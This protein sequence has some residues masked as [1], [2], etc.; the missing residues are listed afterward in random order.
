MLE[1]RPKLEGGSARPDTDPAR[2]QRRRMAIAVV[3]LL[4]ALAVVALKDHDAWFG[5]GDGQLIADGDEPDANAPAPTAAANPSASTSAPAKAKPRRIVEREP[6]QPVVEP[7]IVASNRRAL[8]P[9]DI[10]VVAGNKHR[11]VQPSNNAVRVDMSD[12]VPDTG[13]SSDTKLVANAA[14][15]ATMSVDTAQA[16]EHPV[17]PSYP[18][19]ARQMKVQGAVVLQALIGADGLIQDLHVISGPGILA[20]A[21]QEAVRQWH[22]K[23]YFENGKP[24]ETQAKITVNFTISTF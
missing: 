4:I 2:K 7:A 9:L 6:E 10:E 17:E 15:H 14:Q 13:Q 21:A 22:F 11:A 16:V 8:P 5:S 19:L 24:V 1:T 20:S 23:P 3:L 12:S 18:V